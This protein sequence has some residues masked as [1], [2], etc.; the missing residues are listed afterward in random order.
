MGACLDYLDGETTQ[1]PDPTPLTPEKQEWA[2]RWLINLGRTRDTLDML[3][4][5]EDRSQR[6]R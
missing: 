3:A 5:I 1:I 2:K 6:P 4:S